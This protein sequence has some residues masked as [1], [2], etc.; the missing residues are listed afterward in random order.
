MKR[1]CTSYRSSDQVIQVL[2]ILFLDDFQGEE[3][4]PKDFE[5]E[6]NERFNEFAQKYSGALSECSK[7]ARTEERQVAINR[8]KGLWKKMVDIYPE[9]SS[10]G[11]PRVVLEQGG[12]LEEE[13]CS[14][15]YGSRYD[16]EEEFGLHCWISFTITKPSEEEDYI[17]INI[18]AHLDTDAGDDKVYFSEPHIKMTTYVN[19]DSLL[20]KHKLDLDKLGVTILELLKSELTIGHTFFSEIECNIKKTIG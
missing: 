13:G 18:E 10:L 2:R 12:N 4:L 7:R 16:L 20:N 15:Y 3:N 9:L 6:W 14:Y 11:E 8:S 5:E 17:D 19:F 1:K